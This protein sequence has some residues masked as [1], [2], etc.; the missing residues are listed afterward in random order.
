[1]KQLERRIWR[2]NTNLRPKMQITDFIHQRGY[3]RQ[4]LVIIKRSSRFSLSVSNKTSV[5]CSGNRLIEFFKI[6]L[7]KSSG[8]LSKSFGLKFCAVSSSMRY[9]DCFPNQNL[10]VW[11]R[12]VPQLFVGGANRSSGSICQLSL[13]RLAKQTT[14]LDSR[15]TA[16]IPCFWHST[17]VVPVP[18]NGSSTELDSSSSNF[19]M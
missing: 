9:P 17:S 4:S 8:S 11:H 1:M 13:V 14:G 3:Q 7:V 5:R 2:A 12:R 6:N 19:F 10:P 16:L 18:Q 15:P